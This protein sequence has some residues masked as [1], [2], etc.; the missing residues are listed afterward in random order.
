MGTGFTRLG[1]GVL[2]CV[3]ADLETEA[4]V[5]LSV[6]PV[7]GVGKPECRERLANRPYAI[8]SCAGSYWTSG[9]G[10]VPIPVIPGENVEDG[11]RFFVNYK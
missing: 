1:G 8:L 4:D 9:L 6:L 10:N 5:D 2:I 3:A 7:T 11:Y